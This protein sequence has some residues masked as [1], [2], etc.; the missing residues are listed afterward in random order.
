M[1][2]EVQEGGDICVPIYLFL[3]VLSLLLHGLFSSCSEQ[4]LLSSCGAQASHCSGFSCCRAQALE[5]SAFSRCGTRAQQLRLWPLEHRLSSCSTQLIALRHV[6]S[7]RSGIEPMSPVLAGRFFTTEPPGK[8]HIFKNYQFIL[9]LPNQIQHQQIFTSCHS[10]LHL[11]SPTE[12]IMV[13][14]SSVCVC[15]RACAYVCFCVF[16]IHIQLFF[17]TL[18][19]IGQKVFNLL[20]FS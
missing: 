14:I 7:F 1:R 8:P 10:L 18:L 13:S 4:G 16:C 6:G 5:H 3:V 11:F 20:Q 2:K 12:R 9:I 15:A 19:W 17:M